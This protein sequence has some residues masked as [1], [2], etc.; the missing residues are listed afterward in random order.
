MQGVHAP[1]ACVQKQ[2]KQHVHD[3]NLEDKPA[4][5]KVIH[6]GTAIDAGFE[7]KMANAFHVAYYVAIQ[8]RPFTDYTELMALQEWTD[9]NMPY[10]SDK[11]VERWV[12]VL[13]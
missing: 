3:I 8:E 9:S 10:R 2:E 6:V 13:D 4:G 7:E 5:L 1:L 11:V 12:G